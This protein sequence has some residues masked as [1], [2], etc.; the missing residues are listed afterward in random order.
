MNDKRKLLLKKGIEN[1][2]KLTMHMAKQ[3]Y[4][5]KDSARSAIAFFQFKDFVE[6]EAP[7]VFRIVKAPEEV[8]H[9]ARKELEA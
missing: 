5:S 6:Q 4:A 7:G 2:G 8:K 1:N 3:L 9:E